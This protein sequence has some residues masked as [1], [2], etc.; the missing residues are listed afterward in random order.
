MNG[1]IS[2]SE[3]SGSQRYHTTTYIEKITNENLKVAPNPFSVMGVIVALKFRTFDE[4]HNQATW[5]SLRG[6]FRTM[7][8][9]RTV[10]VDENLKEEYEKGAR[11]REEKQDNVAK[12]MT[13][14]KSVA[15]KSL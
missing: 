2:E 15:F 14:C 4:C 6:Y 7:V 13:S 9:H 1:R 5:S 3:N 10:W 12:I 11:E 8:L